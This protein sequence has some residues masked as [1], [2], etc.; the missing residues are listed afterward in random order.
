MGRLL[1]VA[2]MLLG[3]STL[4][5]SYLR[6]PFEGLP[7]LTK[8]A[9]RL[10]NSNAAQEEIRTNTQIGELFYSEEAI[11]SYKSF[12]SSLLEDEESPFWAR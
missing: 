1:G 9:F 10:D 12:I 2:V 8:V 4:W 7:E 3:A 6:P 11:D 5:S